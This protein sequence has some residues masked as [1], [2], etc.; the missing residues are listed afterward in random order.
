MSETTSSAP[1]LKASPGD[2]ARWAFW[3]QL[4]KLVPADKPGRMAAMCKL[5]PLQQLASGNG[6]R[7][8]MDEYRRCFPDADPKALASDA[9][10]VAFRVHAEELL[11]S[12]VNEQ[13]NTNYMRWEG[14]ENI[15]K[16]REAGKGV[17]LLYPHSGN[18]M[19]MIAALSLQGHKYT[20]FAARGL[21]PDDVAKANPEVFGHNK[22]R[23]EARQARHDAE[24]RL[25]AVFYNGRPARPHLLGC[26]ER[27]EIVGIA[28]EG[29]L[30][31]NFVVKDYLNRKALLAPGPFEM[32]VESGATIL[33]AIC[34]C[35]P[36]GPNVTTFGTPIPVAGQAWEPLM[37]QTLAQVQ[38][39]L[40]QHSAGYG[41]WLLH[42]LRRAA[43]DDHPLFIDYAPD[44]AWRKYI[45]PGDNL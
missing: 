31:R 18:F 16:A 12:T 35:P 34:W 1:E 26:L 44:D 43:V 3:V 40:R 6:Q 39:W 13:N 5:W 33:P 8:M 21:A 32:A 28:F 4:R 45:R 23:A 37:D 10:R 30:G 22:W 17:L 2:L 24:D 41:I 14:I 25:P 11:L 42:C 20:Q 15:E 38:P 36:D 27:N 29:R 19:M 7:L 9:Y